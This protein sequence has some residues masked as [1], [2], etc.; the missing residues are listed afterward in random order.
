MKICSRPVS[1]RD[2]V[3]GGKVIPESEPE[4]PLDGEIITVQ[5]ELWG[6]SDEEEE[7]QL[8]RMPPAWVA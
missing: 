4:G 6:F 5:Y 7:D 2:K 8:E 1:A 3:L